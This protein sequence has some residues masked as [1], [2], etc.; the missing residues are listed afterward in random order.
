MNVV[1]WFDT[2]RKCK[3][4]Q[5]VYQDIENIHNTVQSVEIGLFSCEEYFKKNWF[6]PDSLI[7]SLSSLFIERTKIQHIQSK[8]QS[9]RNISQLMSSYIYQKTYTSD[10]SSS[11]SY[12]LEQL[13]TFCDELESTT[14]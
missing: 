8:I 9:K 7:R 1:H 3:N 5:Q 12:F 2:Y 13:H 10:V 11:M 6:T 14:Q 4:L